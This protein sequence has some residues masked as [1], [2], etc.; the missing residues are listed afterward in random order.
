MT[1]MALNTNETKAV[2]DAAWREVNALPDHSF[3]LRAIER[4]VAQQFNR[5]VLAKQA[6]YN[7]PYPIKTDIA[8][9]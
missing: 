5:A 3:G 1:T 6:A 4:I 9:E 2:L 8:A 7:S